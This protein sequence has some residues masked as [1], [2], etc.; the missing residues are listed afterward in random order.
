LEL[1]RVMGGSSQLSKFVFFSTENQRR[2]VIAE[3]LRSLIF[4]VWGGGTKQSTANH[5]SKAF[6]DWPARS[7]RR[8]HSG[9]GRQRS[10]PGFPPSPVFIPSSRRRSRYRS[11]SASACVWGSRADPGGGERL[12][13]AA[14]AGMSR[15]FKSDPSPRRGVS[16]RDGRFLFQIWLVTRTRLESRS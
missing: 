4:A 13:G 7:H 10:L 5:L 8:A 11:T 9:L 6:L 16:D 1:I 12:F 14:G 3:Y 2:I 15:K